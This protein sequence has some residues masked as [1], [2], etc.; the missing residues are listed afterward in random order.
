[1]SLL[2]FVFVQVNH[3]E[4]GNLV[5]ENKYINTIYTYIYSTRLGST[6]PLPITYKEI[7]VKKDNN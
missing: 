4:K 1:M 2:V 5:A 7:S 3:C 6:L